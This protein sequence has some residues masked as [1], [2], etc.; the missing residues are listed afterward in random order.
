M[1][2][3]LSSFYFNR[4][5]Y[6]SDYESKL[7]AILKKEYACDRAN[8]LICLGNNDELYGFP[9]I[10]LRRNGRLGRTKCLADVKDRIWSLIRE[11][12]N[13]INVRDCMGLSPLHLICSLHSPGQMTILKLLCTQRTSHANTLDSLSRTPL[14]HAVNPANIKYHSECNERSSSL[15]DIVRLLIKHGANVNAMECHGL[16]P[17]HLVLD[18]Y[19]SGSSNRLRELPELVKTL[20]ES[21]ASLNLKAP[22]GSSHS[23]L[24]PLHLACRLHSRPSIDVMSMLITPEFIN[25]TDHQMKTPLHELLSIGDKKSPHSE[26]SFSSP[27]NFIVEKAGLLL[28]HGADV[29]ARDN[30]GVTP[31]LMV[32]ENPNHKYCAPLVR[33]LL[34]KGASPNVKLSQNRASPLHLVCKHSDDDVVE[35]LIPLFLKSGARINTRDYKLLTPFHCALFPRNGV[36][37][38]DCYFLSV[39]TLRTLVK[40]GA[41]PALN[42]LQENG[43]IHLVCVSP[44]PHLKDVISFLIREGCKLNHGNK[45]GNTPLLHFLQNNFDKKSIQ[46]L[47]DLGADC[48]VQNLEGISP[49]HLVSRS[50]EYH[51]DVHE[52]VG[53]LLK[54]GGKVNAQDC[55]GNTPIHYAVRDESTTNMK[56][57][58]KLLHAGANLNITNSLGM[59]PLHIVC[60]NGG[61][62]LAQTLLDFGADV[63]LKDGDGNTPLHIAQAANE[64]ATNICRVLVE[65]GA[66]LSARNNR[67]ATP[68]VIMS[69]NTYH[70]MI[71]HIVLLIA[72]GKYTLNK[73]ERKLL[74][75]NA[76][77]RKRYYDCFS[78]APAMKTQFIANSSI[79]LLDFL[80]V[81]NERAVRYFRNPDISNGV[82]KLAESSKYRWYSSMI[83]DKIG[84]LSFLKTLFDRTS[85]SLRIMWSPFPFPEIL[86]ER[87]LSYLDEADMNALNRAVFFAS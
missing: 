73:E 84:E 41:D 60:S 14:H 12:E 75:N 67:N 79:T 81:D 13:L 23:S 52:I 10:V 80:L 29:N 77:F 47:I 26:H 64:N 33:L 55:Y 51:D 21:G 70:F 72:S 63:N 69:L 27:C 7:I 56:A 78:C 28:H 87:V 82:N 54:G 50:L 3:S 74:D 30:E 46:T 25:S 35:Q 38:K 44:N 24:T 59:A 34:E 65:K 85:N 49:L 17:L 66:D 6:D 76:I 2:A 20:V 4:I 48:R 86:V 58:R 40:Y 53:I 11:D 15:V 32:L 71:G 83:K 31:L 43:S 8:T 68:F 16:T 62:F 37:S 42:D 18:Y 61:N 19:R 39:S 9:E 1:M 22:S 5:L 57:I 36:L 45:H